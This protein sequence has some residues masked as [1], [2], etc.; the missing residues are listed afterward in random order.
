MH[1]NYLAIGLLESAYK[2]NTENWKKKFWLAYQSKIVAK[3]ANGATAL[4][5]LSC[6]IMNGFLRSG[7]GCIGDGG[8]SSKGI[9]LINLLRLREW[10]ERLLLG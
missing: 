8:S 7:G 6:G 2:H 4:A 10:L 5:L 3:G 9:L 1:T